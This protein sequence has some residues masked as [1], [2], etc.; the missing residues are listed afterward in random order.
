MVNSTWDSGPVSDFDVKC[1][2]NVKL[3]A[4]RTSVAIPISAVIGIIPVG[5]PSGVVYDDGHTLKRINAATGK[6]LMA[7]TLLPL[8]K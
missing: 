5:G 2:T 6:W 7:D 4:R 3:S 8:M 1:A